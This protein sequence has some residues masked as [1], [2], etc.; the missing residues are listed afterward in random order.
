[1]PYKQNL[2]KYSWIFKQDGVAGF[3]GWRSMN[4]GGGMAFATQRTWIDV[5]VQ[6]GMGRFKLIQCWLILPSGS[7]SLSFGACGFGDFGRR[8]FCWGAGSGGEVFLQLSHSCQQGFK[9]LLA[10]DA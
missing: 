2:I 8:F 5:A 6:C 4:V 9:S 3:L 10:W 7:A 1:M